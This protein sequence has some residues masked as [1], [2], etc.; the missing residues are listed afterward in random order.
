MQDTRSKINVPESC[1]LHLASCILRPGG[2]EYTVPVISNAV[3]NFRERAIFEAGRYGSDSWVFV[4][5]LLQ[6]SRDAGA[7]GV[8][9]SATRREGRDRIKCGDDGAGMSFE[10]ARRYL[11]TLYASSKR[12]RSKTAGR[13][14]I[15]FW[16]VLRF[17]PDAIVIRSRP[18]DGS[19]GWLVRLDGH[20][21]RAVREPTVMEPG[22]E[23]V[24]ERPAQGVDLENAVRGA[25]LR[26]AP[27]LS[28][29]DRPEQPLEVRVNGRI[30]RSEPVLPPPSLSF[31][32]RG[33]RGAVGLGEEPRV[34][35]F[36]HGLKVRDAAS[37]DDLLLVSGPGRP[38]IPTTT[39]GSAPKVLID[40]RDL[41]VLMA[42]GDARE[43][44][45][46]RRLVAIGHRE[47]GHLVRA[48]LDRHARATRRGG[49]GEWIRDLRAG[50]RLP[51]AAVIGVA[52][53]VI[54]G[55][56]WLVLERWPGGGGNPPVVP[57]VRV[58][59][60]RADR[61][62]A[63]YRGLEN[64]YRGPSVEIL[65]RVSPPVDLHYR[66]GDQDL[67]FAALLVTGLDSDGVPAGGPSTATRSYS[68]QPCVERCVEIEMT[69]DAGAGIL[70][71]PVP[72]GHVVDPES[73][74]LDGG[75]VWV[76]ATASGQ[77]AIRLEE[78]QA[79]R[80][81]YQSSPGPGSAPIVGGDW[82]DLPAELEAL[83]A[84]LDKLDRADR[85]P[86]AADYVRR[87]VR[88]D[89]SLATSTRLLKARRGGLDLFSR[90][91][92][93]GAGDCDVQNALLAGVLDHAGV[94]SRLA[95]GWVGSD[96]QVLAGLHAWVEFLGADGR[97][98]VVDASVDLERNS[99]PV[100]GATGKV[101]GSVASI[102]DGRWM[103]IAGGALLVVGTAAV[104]LF[105]R[106]WRRSLRPGDGSDLSDLL[107]GA[108]ARPEAFA[109]IRPLF[110]RRVVPLLKRPPVSLAQARDGLA[111][112]RLGSG[113]SNSR[114][115]VEAAAAGGL[116]IDGNSCEG[117][118]VAEALGA[119]D[120]DRWQ[121]ILE[122][123]RIEP[124]TARVEEALDAAGEPC[125]L[126]VASKVGQHIAVLDGHA[127]GLGRRSCRVVV[128]EES[129]LWRVVC[130]LGRRRPARAALLLADSVVHLIGV[131]PQSRPRCLGAL[132]EAALEESGGGAS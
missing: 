103:L 37:L 83:A 82:P 27:F 99:V 50:F 59:P 116:V 108:A 22:T 118:A 6:N 28:C 79:G 119:V 52:V 39:G 74:R 98:T 97:W 35:I 42:R 122:R 21:E 44:H 91:L 131:P 7:R 63:P 24:L 9:I 46:L 100:G 78:A 67:N 61:E 87:R 41:S 120:L 110:S 86:V 81:L 30:V 47:L 73:V 107:R 130:G 80:L 132:A 127:F 26:D 124:L 85:V 49:V 45:A 129:E 93:V 53:A 33:L 76:V 84:D 126:R 60:S 109:R 5:E 18:D 70:R 57:A 101:V 19:N 55:L 34:E 71:L 64:R 72:T 96:G 29:R 31:R 95:L 1:I 68:G 104:V 3:N 36:A 12:G 102:A 111:R 94:P 123:S 88:Y 48:E 4:R 14:G 38:P 56:G 121:E 54:A 77:P 92:A 66:P 10:H 25:V 125:R 16:S 89:R 112:G 117:R 113:S 32:S 62:P 43:D 115:A 51:R 23:I 75:P 40:S 114:L 11:F 13:F 90:T 128:D 65:G 58:S 17:S 8:W 105:R 20:L 15:G 2:W 106:P 69:V